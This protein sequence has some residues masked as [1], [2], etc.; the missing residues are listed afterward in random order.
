[1]NTTPSM[2]SNHDTDHDRD[3]DWD[4]ERERM[5]VKD[6]KTRSNTWDDTHQVVPSPYPAFCM[7]RVFFLLYNIIPLARCE[8]VFCLCM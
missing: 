2:R 7:G 6:D 1:M 4:G 5:V 8:R 3:R